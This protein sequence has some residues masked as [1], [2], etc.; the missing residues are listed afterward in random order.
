MAS[1]LLNRC[2]FLKRWKHTYLIRLINNAFIYNFSEKEWNEVSTD[3]IKNAIVAFCNNHDIAIKSFIVGTRFIHIKLKCTQSSKNA[4]LNFL[5][6]DP[7]GKW[8][9]IFEHK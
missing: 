6:L 9:T 1:N 4:F 8:I 5:A 2:N 7:I 3:K